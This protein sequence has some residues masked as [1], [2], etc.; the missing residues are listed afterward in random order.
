MSREGKRD[1]IH[2]KLSDAEK[3]KIVMRAKGMAEAGY[4]TR[5]IQKRLHC[6]TR[7][8]E[9]WAKDLGIEMPPKKRR[10]L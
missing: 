8:I 9:V 7:S 6:G 5:L 1:G 10:G 4:G 2:Q 3:R